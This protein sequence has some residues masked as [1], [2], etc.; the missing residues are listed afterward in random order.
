MASTDSRILDAA[1]ITGP[2][3][4]ASYAHCR[5]LH[6][7]YG[8]SYYLATKLLPPWKRPYVHAL[9]GFARHADEIVDNG[10]PDSRATEFDHWRATVAARLDGDAEADAVTRALRHTLRTWAIPRAHVE[11]FLASMA[12]DLTV[13]RYPTHADLGAYMYGSAAVIGLQMTPILGPLDDEAFDRAQELGYAFQL[14]NFIR[15]IGEDLERGRVYLPQ[16][17]LDRFG[18]TASDLAA[19]RAD[20]RVRALI[21]Y[22]IDR[23]RTIYASARPGIDMLE[24]SSRPCVETAYALYSGILDAIERLDHQILHRR[25]RVGLARR[26]A[27]AAPAYLR[28]RSAFGAPPARKGVPA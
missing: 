8:R 14:T 18:V 21:A 27:I 24:P 23:T 28:A 7:R 9:Y 6:A 4:R 26:A 25:A 16:E 17:D 5:R 3:L 2:A 20:D 1:G 15:D 22:E 13:T 19:P 10:E 11:A 12:A